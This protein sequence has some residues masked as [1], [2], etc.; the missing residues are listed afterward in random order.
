[1]SE[2]NDINVYL[3][4]GN[5]LYD[6]QKY[7][8][9]INEYDTV[10]TL[11]PKN[12]FAF[13]NKGL[14]L[15]SLDK[16][17]SAIESFNKALNIKSDYSEAYY[18]IGNVYLATNEN[19]KAIE[20]FKKAIE[21]DTNYRDAYFNCAIAF[22]IIKQYTEAIE[23][24]DKAISIDPYYA[25]AYHNK[26]YYY[27]LLG[28]FKKSHEYYEKAIDLY[29]HDL[30]DPISK[31][32]VVNCLYCGGIQYNIFG[33]L[34]EAE[35]LFSKGLEIMP[36]D[37]GILSG[38]GGI[39]KERKYNNIENRTDSHWKSRNFYTK[40]K[41]ALDIQLKS[42]IQSQSIRDQ[43]NTY[44]RI[45]EINIDMEEFEE[46][47]KNFTQL[48]SLSKDTDSN[49]KIYAGAETYAGLGVVYYR[50][51]DYQKAFNN[52]TKAHKRNM[53][54][55]VTWSN[56]GDTL[57]KLNRME[58]AEK[59]YLQILKIAPDSIEAN[60]GLSEAYIKRGDDNR[61][62]EMYEQSVPYITKAINLAK[63]NLG[64]K[65]LTENEIAA[66]YYSRAYAA[67]KVFEKSN[68]IRKDIYLT[69]AIEDFKKCIQHNSENQKAH[70][71][72]QKLKEYSQPIPS[73]VHESN[74]RQ[75][76]RVDNRSNKKSSYLPNRGVLRR[77][78]CK[79][80]V[81]ATPTQT[82]IVVATIESVLKG[83][84]FHARSHCPSWPT[85]AKKCLAPNGT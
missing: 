80:R 63:S 9:A 74:P 67:V 3:E 51:G 37:V 82:T 13:Y 47:E 43:M 50:L 29:Q 83:Q 61:D 70:R 68:S 2:N 69:E 26:A 24:N 78:S 25:Y 60:L 34:D 12:Y 32:D 40:A 18:G 45:G 33:E 77:K 71:A 30:P 62:E 54:D 36:N 19:D 81:V 66:A 46:A 48:L 27:S 56:L 38:L 72:L 73:P 85:A 57:V 41:N 22:S 28:K 65:R 11:D 59:E 58:D 49:A 7:T 35:I 20:N 8:E 42:M 76:L 6:Q 5:E 31:K 21:Y 84:D 75:P 64:S 23:F 79:G 39:Y 44:Q 17:E 4:K 55:F 52:F 1:M 53:D 10:T 15:F 14:S 16:Y